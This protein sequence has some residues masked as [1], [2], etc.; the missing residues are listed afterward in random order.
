[1]SRTAN[2]SAPECRRWRRTQ[3]IAVALAGF[4]CVGAVSP[5]AVIDGRKQHFKAL[6]SSFK[7]VS[8]TLRRRDPDRSALAQKATS[9]RNAARSAAAPA[10]F[11][12][13]SGPGSGRKTSAKAEI[14]RDRREFDRLMQ[15][16]V[17]NTD[18]FARQAGGAPVA[19][20]KA[21]QKAIGAS[22]SA[23]HK[24]F[25]HDG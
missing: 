5:P 9:L 8:E 19:Q 20:L 23:C 16:L 11:A 1:M 21:T 7:D 22:C 12:H 4:M 13:G 14:W 17:A 3:T 2:S 15:Q 6:G 25:R 10:N 24:A 18:L